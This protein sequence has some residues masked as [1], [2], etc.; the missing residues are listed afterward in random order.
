M[1]GRSTPATTSSAPS[2][3]VAARTSEGQ[4]S[5]RDFTEMDCVVSE[6]KISMTPNCFTRECLRLL[7]GFLA[8][9]LVVRVSNASR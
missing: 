5:G 6:K 3:R 9:D 8:S 7:A 4:E 1:W 2:Y